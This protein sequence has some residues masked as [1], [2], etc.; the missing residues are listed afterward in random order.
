MTQEELMQ[1]NSIESEMGAL[2]N[3]LRTARQ[4]LAKGTI[5]DLAPIE[6]DVRWLCSSIESLPGAQ[7]RELHPR[8]VGLLEEINYLG[9]NLRAGL[10]ELAQLLGAAGERTR[11]LSAYATQKMNKP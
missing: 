4:T 1:R 9:E 11:A 6:Q 2:A 3:R 7:K 5:V 8:L 10:G